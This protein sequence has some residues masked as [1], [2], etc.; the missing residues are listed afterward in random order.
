MT[1]KK[2]E[3]MTKEHDKLGTR[4]GLILTKFNNNERLTPKVLAEEFAVSVRTIQKDI[5]ERLSYLPIVKEEGCYRL[6]AYALGKLDYEDI[7]AFAKFSGIRE[8]YPKLDDSLIVDLLNTRVEQKMHVKGYVYENISHKIEDFNTVALAI[9]TTTKLTFSYKDKERLVKPY[10]LINTN[11]IWYVVGV[12]GEE[13]KTFSF[14]KMQKIAN[15][16]TAFTKDKAT[17]K[18]VEDD[19]SLWFVE[20]KIEV[21]LTVEDK[22]AEYFLR[23]PLL[24]EQ[25]TICQDE[26]YLTLSCVVAFEEEILRICRYWIPHIRIVDPASLQEKLENSLK[27]YLHL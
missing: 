21:T 22:V 19:N 13:L 18:I 27:E 6:E 5:N 7:R 1:D 17:L 25:K 4:L 10:R 12:E 16:E 11:G 3:K 14:S 23:R 8:L 9:V 20:E 26:Q 15:T 24:P 2:A